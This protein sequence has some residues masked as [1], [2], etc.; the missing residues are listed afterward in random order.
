MEPMAE[1][2]TVRGGRT[3]LDSIPL[4]GDE[5]VVAATGRALEIIA[6]FEPAGSVGVALACAPDGSE[7]T[8]IAYS[9]ESQELVV[10]RS[11]SS[12]LDGVET[13]PHRARHELLPGERLDLR[14]LLDGSVLEII[15]NGRTS[16]ST[17]IYPSR[18]ESHGVRLFGVGVLEMMTVWTMQS[19]WPG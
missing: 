5:V 13:F 19:I 6:Q 14:L 11:R 12:L 15:A 2:Q 1:L 18:G 3:D 9:P 17:R 16:V 10:D 8:R 7:Q 4:D